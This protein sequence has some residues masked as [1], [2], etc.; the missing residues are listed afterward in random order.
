MQQR[1][2]GI[3]FGRYKQNGRINGPY[4]VQCCA[5]ALLISDACRGPWSGVSTSPRISS[6]KPMMSCSGARRSWLTCAMKVD[7][8]L[9]AATASL[10]RGIRNAR[11]GPIRSSCPPKRRTRVNR[12]SG[13]AGDR[14][15]IGIE[16]VRRTAV[17]HVNTVADVVDTR[18]AT[19]EAPADVDRTRNVARERFDDVRRREAS[20]RAVAI[21]C[22]EDTDPWPTDVGHR[23]NQER[24]PHVHPS[25]LESGS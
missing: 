13:Y 16:L 3:F 22:H 8:A 1:M 20:C 25:T 17:D 11:P 15:H 23:C 7:F 10:R 19:R 24:F 5:P 6:D 21:C 12:P 9:L 2:F 14:L 4:P 18:A